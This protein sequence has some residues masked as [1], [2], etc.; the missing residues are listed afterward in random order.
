M[1]NKN[2]RN[3]EKQRRRRLLDKENNEMG[4]NKCMRNASEEIKTQRESNL[5]HQQ[6]GKIKTYARTQDNH[7][8]SKEGR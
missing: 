8:A 4:Y 3:I 5:V 6:A 1:E 7:K 2:T